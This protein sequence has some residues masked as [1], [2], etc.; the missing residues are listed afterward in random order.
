[1]VDN[2]IT[3]LNSKLVSFQAWKDKR[4]HKPEHMKQADSNLDSK[5]YAE[6]IYA[7]LTK[8]AKITE[9]D[10]TNENISAVF[11]SIADVLRL[12]NSLEEKKE[13]LAELKKIHSSKLLSVLNPNKLATKLMT[14]ALQELNFNIQIQE[15][16]DD[17]E[18]FIDT[19]AMANSRLEAKQENAEWLNSMFEILFNTEINEGDRIMSYDNLMGLYDLALLKFEHDKKRK[20]DWTISEALSFA[21]DIASEEFAQEHDYVK[22][23]AA[24]KK[25]QNDKHSPSLLDF[26]NFKLQN[27][28]FN[29]NGITLRKDFMKSI[30]KYIDDHH[31]EFAEDYV[32]GS[33][34][35]ILASLSK[36]AKAGQDRRLSQE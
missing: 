29:I 31:Q 3:G 1:M 25:Q 2:N 30:L 13:I 28:F 16:F 11:N 32:Y 9:E 7:N 27:S 19:Q 23:L 4:A 10:E 22:S 18:D 26:N 36:E 21:L 33:S 24:E 20:P 34:T 14:N 5:V 15:E 8:L 35:Q 17:G 6:N 12:D